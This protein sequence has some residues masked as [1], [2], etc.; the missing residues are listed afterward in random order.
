MDE[1]L[2]K[3]KE[4]VTREYLGKA[5]IHGVG[6]SRSK[7]ALRIYVEPDS[8]LEQKELLEEIEKKATPYKVLKV[9]E[10]KPTIT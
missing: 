2:D 6:I 8:S 4:R 5:G 3:I 1:P 7:N 10:E 9:V